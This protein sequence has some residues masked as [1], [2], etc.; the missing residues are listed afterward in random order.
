MPIGKPVRSSGASCE[1]WTLHFGEATNRSS[2]IA[3]RIVA[4]DTTRKVPETGITPPPAAT[5][6]MMSPPETSRWNTIT[7][8]TN[9]SRSCAW[10]AAFQLFSIVSISVLIPIRTTAILASCE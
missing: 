4:T 8:E 7:M 2:H 9:S 3:R 10:K 1:R 6:R 5:T